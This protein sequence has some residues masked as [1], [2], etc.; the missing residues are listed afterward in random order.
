MKGIYKPKNMTL[1]KSRHSLGFQLTQSMSREMLLTQ[2][3][4][5]A[6]L[7]QSKSMIVIRTMKNISSQGFQH[8]EELQLMIEMN[9]KK[10]EIQSET[11]GNSLP[12]KLHELFC[13]LPKVS[14]ELW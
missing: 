13:I 3:D 5:I 2:F 12:T 14:S 11:I 7:I 10:Q 9:L 1:P 8:F 6:N 4:S